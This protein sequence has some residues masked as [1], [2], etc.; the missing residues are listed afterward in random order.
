MLKEMFHEIHKDLYGKPFKRDWVVKVSETEA[1]IC[2]CVI[3][4][5]WVDDRQISAKHL[6]GFKHLKILA[7]SS[8]NNISDRSFLLTTHV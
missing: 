6:L 7:G 2:D 4:Q 3:V 8:F 1:S 5:T